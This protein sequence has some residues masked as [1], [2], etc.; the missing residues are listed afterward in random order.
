M[1]YFYIFNLKSDGTISI[2][3]LSS[4]S[5]AQRTLIFTLH[6]LTF[7]CLE[8]NHLFLASCVPRRASSHPSCAFLIFFFHLRLT[9][10]VLSST[11]QF[12]PHPTPHHSPLSLSLSYISTLH[13]I[14]S[15]IPIV[16]IASRS[17]SIFFSTVLLYHRLVFVLVH[18]SIART[19]HPLA[20]YT[21]ARA[22]ALNSYYLR[23]LLFLSCHP[24][25]LA[26]VTSCSSQ[27]CSHIIIAHQ[28]E[29]L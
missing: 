10:S 5:T 18:Y 19:V 7:L 21:R 11:E 23:S 4:L 1:P 14:H 9:S 25:L 2:S 17:Y 15:R 8:G 22:F 29:Y 24:P 26:F 3:R 20:L 16:F 12:P 13:C 6:Y 28:W 27:I